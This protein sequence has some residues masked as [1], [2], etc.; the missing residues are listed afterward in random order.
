MLIMP[1]S[2]L[3]ILMQSFGP[4]SVIGIS[5]IVMFGLGL[6]VAVMAFRLLTT[7]EKPTKELPV[8][9]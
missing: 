4:K 5:S 9:D 2:A 7:R 1:L 3:L 8:T 6:L